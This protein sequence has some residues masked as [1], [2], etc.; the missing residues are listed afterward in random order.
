MLSMH[1]ATFARLL[2]RGVLPCVALL[3]GAASPRAARD[4][5]RVAHWEVL[6]GRPTAPELPAVL[7]C[8]L[9]PA[10]ERVFL[11]HGSE[12]AEYDVE[13]DAWTDDLLRLPARVGSG[14]AVTS[15]A[16]GQ[17]LM[18]RGGDSRDFWRVRP[19]TGVV[20]ALPST[21]ASVGSGAAIAFD[22]ERGR[23]LVLRG[24][25]TV[26]V[27]SF[28]FASQSWS[29]I[30]DSQHNLTKVG[31]TKGGIIVVD[32]RTYAWSDHHF[33][34]Y[35]PDVGGWRNF[36]SFGFR[37]GR[38]GASFARDRRTE[39]RYITLGHD[40]RT[41]GIFEATK[42]SWDLLR[43]RL[44]ARY[45]GDGE[46]TFVADRGGRPHL[47]VYDVLG[48][49]VMYRIALSDLE[50]ITLDSPASDVGSAWR[51]LHEEWGASLVRADT[52]GLLG[53]V[54]SKWYFTRFKGIRFV[55]PR[56]NKWSR[57]PGVPVVGRLPDGLAATSDG[58]RMVYAF[59]GGSPL[60]VGVDAQ[61]EKGQTLAEPD[62]DAL[63]GAQL[64][65]LDGRVH[66]LMGG[67]TRAHRVFDPSTGEWTKWRSLPEE[68]TPV[69]QAGSG[70]VVSE[71]RIVA[72]SGREA[73][74]LDVWG[75]WSKAADLPH[76][77]SS[78]GG[79][80]AADPTSARIF[81]VEGGGSTRLSIVDLRGARSEQELELPDAVSIRGNRAF[82]WN[83][84]NHTE[85]VVMRGHETNEIF[86]LDLETLDTR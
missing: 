21:P 69:G 25:D 81:L 48:G 39:A 52:G 31:F 30:P 74:R 10:G 83:R 20:E 7:A 59:A 75:H 6:E 34:V 26:D 23:A 54:G 77:V 70:L 1:T 64:A 66:A 5:E 12:V 71:G 65:F 24:G 11:V 22:A 73:W 43:P 84:G 60:F 28:D 61:T 55:D 49:N 8:T 85:L 37:P 29:T 57:Y 82:V 44:P 4:D 80:V 16:D 35:D 53:S 67:E 19:D 76:A 42:R 40:S 27:W 14:V 56:N 51:S 58:E 9:G 3:A 50:R 45:S 17:L 33:K 68:A 41:L 32:G 46:R 62:L 18:L 63:I 38:Y 79:M 78:N 13:A 72:I 15:D 2:L 36:M 47:F 86:T